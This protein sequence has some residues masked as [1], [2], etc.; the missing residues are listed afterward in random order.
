MKLFENFNLD[1]D[2]Y[3]SVIRDRFREISEKYEIFEEAIDPSYRGTYPIRKDDFFNCFTFY[4]PPKF[5]NIKNRYRPSS[6][7]SIADNYFTLNFYLLTDPSV[8]VDW[9]RGSSNDVC[10]CDANFPELRSD[11]NDFEKSIN[12]LSK[13]DGLCFKLFG[14]IHSRFAMVAGTD[15][16]ILHVCY[17]L[18][19]I[20]IKQI[21][22]IEKKNVEDMINGIGYDDET[23]SKFRK[24]GYN[25][26]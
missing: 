24:L 16:R 23:K 2:E 9:S 22:E 19:L 26:K 20:S 4:F 10:E 5:P 8:A 21:Q 25:I 1:A 13:I 18:K 17:Q 3:I 11:L 6:V 7:I 15:C 14:T 12:S